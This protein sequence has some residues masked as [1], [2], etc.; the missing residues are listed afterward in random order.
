ML[1]A[2]SVVVVKHFTTLWCNCS[3]YKKTNRFST[4]INYSEPTKDSVS[5]GLSVS[6]PHTLPWSIITS[7]CV[8]INIHHSLWSFTVGVQSRDIMREK[9]TAF[10]SGAERRSLSSLLLND[11]PNKKNVSLSAH[12]RLSALGYYRRPFC[13]P[14]MSCSLYLNK[15][16]LSTLDRTPGK[17]QLS[18]VFL[19][20]VFAVWSCIILIYFLKDVRT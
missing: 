9:T 10:Q 19:N 5:V 17:Y 11:L 2:T 6:F 18:V 14:L 12:F 20:Q 3:T 8:S 7:P 4:V 15:L 16:S 13:S 1:S